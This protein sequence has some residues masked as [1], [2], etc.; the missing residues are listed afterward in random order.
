MFHTLAAVIGK[1]GVPNVDNFPSGK[2][3]VDQTALIVYF[4][5]KKPARV[6]WGTEADRCRIL[7]VTNDE[8]RLY[9][10]SN[11]KQTLT[12]KII[13]DVVEVTRSLYGDLFKKKQLKNGTECSGPHA[14][15]R[16]LESAK[17]KRRRR[18]DKR[19]RQC[20]AY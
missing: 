1:A 14:G 2:Q 11:I 5:D 9:S 3:P 19:R 6:G 7:Y 17:V 12:G 18:E 16:T 20:R 10:L 15:L 8:H 13:S 4:D